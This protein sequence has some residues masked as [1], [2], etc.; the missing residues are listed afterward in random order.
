MELDAPLQ[1]GVLD[2]QAL[3]RLRSLGGSELVADMI[4]LF[5]VHGPE[6]LQSALEAERAGDLE[7]VRRAVHSL[8]STAG[9]LGAQIV[10]RLAAEI[11]VDRDTGSVSRRMRELELRF[12][13]ARAALEDER[14][15]LPE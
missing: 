11:E 13:E 5:L 3:A 10:Q 6:R 8:A 7:G 9:T 14:R 4:D 12:A 1:D 15:R 2:P